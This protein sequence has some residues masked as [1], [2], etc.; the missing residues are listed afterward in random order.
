MSSLFCSR[1]GSEKGWSD[2]SEKNW[3]RSPRP[4][5]DEYRSKNKFDFNKKKGTSF[6]NSSNF[7]KQDSSPA[8]MTVTDPAPNNAEYTYSQI[9]NESREVV[10][11]WFHD[12][13]NFFCQLVETR[14]MTVFICF[15]N[16]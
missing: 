14:V 9:A 15:A 6:G 4:N 3:R 1:D 10:V 13:T 12:P 2:G 16:H 7:T 11:S 8:N 5:N